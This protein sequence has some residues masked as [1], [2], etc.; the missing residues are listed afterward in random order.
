[1]AKIRPFSEVDKKDLTGPVEEVV[2]SL[3]TMGGSSVTSGALCGFKNTK[4]PY[5]TSDIYNMSPYIELDIPVLN[6]FLAGSKADVLKLILNKKNL[7]DIA[8]G[9]VFYNKL[10]GEEKSFSAKDTNDD[11]NDNILIGGDYIK[12]LIDQ[13]DVDEEIDMILYDIVKSA[14]KKSGNQVKDS[15]PLSFYGKIKQNSDGI[16]IVDRYCFEPNTDLDEDLLAKNIRAKVSEMMN[17]FN[18][19]LTYLLALRESKQ[20]ISDMLMTI[21]PVMPIGYRR[22]FMNKEDKLTVAYD[23]LYRRSVK[24]RQLLSGCN[25]KL[26]NIM[27]AYIDVVKAVKN[28]MTDKENVYDKQYKPLTDQLKGKKGHIR[29][30]MQGARVDYS[31]RSVIISDPN[32][33]FDSVGVPINMLEKLLEVEILK[34]YK[35]ATGNKSKCLTMSKRELRR[36]IVRKIAKNYY[37]MIG[38]QPTLY[39]LGLRCYKIVPTDGDA[40]VLNPLSCPA[41]NADFDGDQMHLEAIISLIAREEAE[42]LLGAVHN[43]FLPRNGECHIAP[44]QEIIHGL[45]KASS[46]NPEDFPNSKHV[47]VES[48]ADLFKKVIDKTINIYDTV[49]MSGYTESVGKAAI[50]ACLV[51]RLRGVRL[52]VIPITMDKNVKEKPV[53][54]KFFK[55][56][57]K[58]IAI[59]FKEDFVDIINKTV[60]LGFAITNIF[61]PNISVINKPDVS[62]LKLDFEKRVKEREELYNMGLETDEAFSTFFSSELRKLETDMKAKINND[63]GPSNGYVEMKNSGARG[64]DSNLLQIFGMKGRVKKNETEAFNTIMKH[65]H[66]DQLDALEHGITAYGGR[67]GLIDKSI[68]TYGPGYFSRKISHVTSP[69]SIVTEDCGDTEG[70][71]LDYDFVKQFVDESCTGDDVI[72][73]NYVKPL[74]VS[75]IEGKYIVGEEYMVETKQEASVMYDKYIAEVKDG[76]FIKKEGIRLRSPITCKKPCCAKCFGRS[77][78]TMAKAIVGEPVGA[79]TSGAIGE[80]GTQLIMKNFQSGGVAGVKN[81]TSSF[82]LMESYAHLYDMHKEGKPVDYDYIAPVEGMVQTV[83]MGNGTKLVKIMGYNSSGRLCN[84]LGNTKIIVYEDLELKDY[85]RVGDT[86]QKHIGYKNMPEI[87][88]YLGVDYA[89]KY[90]AMTLFNIYRKEAFVSFQYF[91]ILVSQMSFKLCIKGNSYFKS[92]CFYTLQEYYDHD[93]DDCIF[94]D[95]IK[96][97][98]DVPLYRQDV[99][100]TMFMEDL[101]RGVGRSIILSGKDEMKLPIVRYSFGLK[102]QFG[103]AVPGYLEKRGNY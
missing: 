71:L 101:R 24:L 14:L 85:V 81:L 86:I 79:L 68:E 102:L 8:N 9:M 5:N 42:K 91:E 94:E 100:S 78:S 65:S 96:G 1:M 36:S 20:V 56:F 6:P 62:Q 33:S 60:K 11:Y 46:I 43:V 58:Y 40:I 51:P 72:D 52:G 7:V 75:I 63:L 3:S 57:N 77:L 97:I 89:K 16:V 31:G 30:Y 93:H 49:T 34:A 64:K 59:N 32:M 99:F 26:K 82:G 35:D 55:E 74:M 103:S 48:Y 13:L 23:N 15:T 67:E 84:K 22:K 92:G 19:R 53:S 4:A 39:N 38:R 44:R 66:V 29:H 45:W 95:T 90:L 12:F 61:V 70:L 69:V 25:L 47:T 17:N 76:E 18:C 2:G 50:R 10:T 83:S 98:A 54:E 28:I 87:I 73:N 88:K 27:V 21:I 37:I 80:P 41:F